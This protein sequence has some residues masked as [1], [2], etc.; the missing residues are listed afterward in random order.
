[1]ACLSTF[2]HVRTII[3]D[4]KRPNSHTNYVESWDLKCFVIELLFFRFFSGLLI[5]RVMM[6][7]CV[8]LSENVSIRGGVPGVWRLS[9]G[10]DP[11]IMLQRERIKQTSKKTFENRFSTKINNYLLSGRKENDNEAFLFCLFLLMKM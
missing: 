5:C 10:D 11:E 6:S 3:D 9:N 8:C 4:E 2:S 1:M 7:L